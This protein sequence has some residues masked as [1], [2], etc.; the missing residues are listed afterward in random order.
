MLAPVDVNAGDYFGVSSMGI[1]MDILRFTLSGKQ[2]M[3]KKPDVNSVHY[4][5]YGQIHKPALV[6]LFGAVLGYAGYNRMHETDKYPEYYQK[7]KDLQVS[8]SPNAEKGYF[9][10]KM[11]CFNNSVGYASREQGG[12]LIVKEQWIENPSWDIF[13]LLD[14]DEA[15][16][17]AE[18]LTERKCIYIPYLGKNDHL[19]D[20]AQVRIAAGNISAESVS[21]DC[22]FPRNKVQIDSDANLFGGV[23]NQFKY[24]EALPVGLDPD[25]NQYILEKFIYTNM[26]LRQ[27][28]EQ[29]WNVDGKQILFY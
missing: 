27:P 14:C 5:T 18:F 28:E 13:V 2:A 11:I 3:F 17:L 1:N 26:I 9:A 15:R 22:L 10:K 6:G 23:E 20:I 21:L 25:T 7:L 8:I 24:E 12:N 4:Y 29:V 19:A 16:K